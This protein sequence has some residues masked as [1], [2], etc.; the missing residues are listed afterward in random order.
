MAPKVVLESTHVA[1]LEFVD[2]ESLK[3][4]ALDLPV[5]GGGRAG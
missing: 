1:S 5:E 2:L 4:F 3:S